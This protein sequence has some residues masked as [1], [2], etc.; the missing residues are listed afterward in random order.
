M[1][2]EQIHEPGTQSNTLYDEQVHDA[3]RQSDIVY[4]SVVPPARSEG[5]K[6]WTIPKPLPWQLHSLR[7]IVEENISPKL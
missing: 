2:D 1:Y 6:T 4:V 3:G 7:N 5:S